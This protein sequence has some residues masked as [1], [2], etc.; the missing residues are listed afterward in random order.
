M[1]LYLSTF[2]AVPTVNTPGIGYKY[3]YCLAL[4]AW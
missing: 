3:T 2:Y 4:K 1:N